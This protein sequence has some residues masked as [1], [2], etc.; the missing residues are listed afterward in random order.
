M[1]SWVLVLK[2]EKFIPDDASLSG[3]LATCSTQP[4]MQKHTEWRRNNVYSYAR[5]RTEEDRKC[6]DN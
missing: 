1:M 5:Y 2:F 3:L 6:S 4:I